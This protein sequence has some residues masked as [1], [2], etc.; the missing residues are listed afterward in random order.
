MGKVSA[1]NHAMVVF[2]TFVLGNIEHDW[3]AI[4]YAVRGVKAFFESVPNGG[5]MI[6][7][8]CRLET[9]LVAASIWPHHNGCASIF[10]EVC[11]HY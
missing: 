2:C 1:I 8:C 5:T 3:G 11:A 7:R 6:G 10:D 9:P 4:A